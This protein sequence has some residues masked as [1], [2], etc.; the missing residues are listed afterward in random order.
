MLPYWDETSRES[1]TEGVPWAL[2]RPLIELDGRAIRNPL[3]SFVLQANVIDW[4]NDVVAVN[5]VRVGGRI[6]QGY[7]RCLDA[8]NYTAF[9]DPTSAAQW[10]DEQAPAA[11][12][13]VPSNHAVHPRS[14]GS[15]S[16][17]SSAGRG[18]VVGCRG[19]IAR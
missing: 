8:P 10:N 7:Q 1:L 4:L 5:G 11:R 18:A 17:G 12:R 3:R 2:T 19:G 15:A 9:S 14:A 16:E 13:Y 6:A